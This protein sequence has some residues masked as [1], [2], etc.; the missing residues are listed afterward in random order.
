MHARTLPLSL[1]HTLQFK[2]GRGGEGFGND[3]SGF[4]DGDNSFGGGGGSFGGPP[5]LEEAEEEW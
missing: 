2:K 1:T 4:G 3:S 5:A